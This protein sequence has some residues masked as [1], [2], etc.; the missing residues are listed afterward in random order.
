MKIKVKEITAHTVDVKWIRL[1]VFTSEGVFILI[2][3]QFRLGQ[4]SK[5]QIA[6]RAING[7]FEK[8]VKVK[9][10]EERKYF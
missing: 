1:E 3:D 5:K 2:T 8:E 7:W 9:V 10:K 6:E 4:L